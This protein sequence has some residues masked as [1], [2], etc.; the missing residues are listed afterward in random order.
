MSKLHPATFVL[1]SLGLAAP[2]AALPQVQSVPQ[3][4]TAAA[5]PGVQPGLPEVHPGEPL[6][7]S[8]LAP[9]VAESW[10]EGLRRD[11]EAPAGP[12][13]NPKLRNGRSGYFQVPPRRSPGFPHSG[14]K[15]L[16]NKWGDSRLGI[17]FR[18]SVALDGVWVAGVEDA[19][20]CAPAVRAI[21]YFGG[22]E[23]GR[24]EWFTDVD[25]TPS[26]FAIDL[27]GID[28]VE[29]EA[30]PAIGDAGWY[31]LD[32]LA[33]TRLPGGTQLQ[34]EPVT[35]DFE[36]LGFEAKLAGSDY[37]GLDWEEGTGF[38][39]T[40]VP[41]PKRP[42]SAGQGIEATELGGAGLF[43]P[44]ATG[45]NLESDFAG[46]ELGDSGASYIPSDC[47]GA[48][49]TTQFVEVVNCALAV[50]DKSTGS[51][52][53]HV[54]LSSFFNASSPGDPRVVFDHDADRWI[55]TATDFN[56]KIYFAFSNSANALGTWY[57]T[58]ITI[59]SGSD[60]NR[61]PDYP[62][63]GVDSQGVYMAAY[64]FG[65]SGDPMTLLA[66]DKAPLLSGSLGTVTAFRN[67]PWEGAIQ[68]CDT[69]GTS[70]YEYL[71][72]VYGSNQIRVR[73]LAGPLT[74]P[75]LTTVGYV[76]VASHSDPPNAPA[77]GSSPGL[78]TVDD[79]LMNACY[80]NGSIYTAHCVSY[81]SKAAAR[82]YQI[83]A[84]SVSLVQ[85]GTVTDST[86]YYF[87]PTIT[88]NAAGDVV[89]GFSGSKSSQYCGAY[90]TGRLAGDP[91]GQMATPVQYKAGTGA[92]NH[93]DGY[94]RNRWGDYSHTS[95]DP[96][97]NSTIWT[98]QGVGLTGNTWGTHA[99]ELAYAGSGCDD[100]TTYCLT[101]PNSVGS[102]ALMS[103]INS[104]SVTSTDFYLAA[105]GLPPS[106]FL[107]FYYG[108]GQGQTVFGN[109]WRCVTSGGVGIFR[110]KPFK[111]DFTGYASQLVD[112]SAPPAGTGGGLGQWIPGDVWN[113]QAW[114]RDPN[115]GGAQFNL[116]DAINL[117]VCP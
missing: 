52:V 26:W 104:P 89:M 75:T 56:T 32:D 112:F 81:N 30:Q 9:V 33:F 72:S 4:Q 68:P 40:I 84:S 23:V 83:N 36:D 21:G 20:A 8:A 24:T 59:S 5:Q 2:L 47:T 115:G 69:Y 41:A 100:P 15:L 86:L 90:Y 117:T 106:Q 53:S 70:S 95:L 6:D 19:E 102:G 60:A 50:Y 18:G 99:A 45:P 29:L 27:V 22:V 77:L 71:V 101:S 92:I 51:K 55:V 35:L 74:S 43:L 88:A 87:F 103:W 17:G 79:R 116:S 80:V 91:A 44:A 82:W 113:V 7:R 10:E 98:I 67:L 46:I 61:S 14:S 28:R 38:G 42:A 78:N 12:P 63:L 93:L 54:T 34:R 76:T 13:S 37:A 111:S 64:M 66:V 96:S 25:E 3:P 97:D 110:F 73:R 94:G 105:D 49:G 57:K 31:T 62:T 58:S 65:G 108:A 16:V 114:Y 48:V 1:A 85:S 11:A 107:M 39:D 109:G